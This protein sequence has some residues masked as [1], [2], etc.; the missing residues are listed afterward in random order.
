[1]GYESEIVVQEND[2]HTH[3]VFED[4]KL[5]YLN[6]DEYESEDEEFMQLYEELWEETPVIEYDWYQEN[7]E[8]PSLLP[9]RSTR[10][11]NKP[12]IWYPEY[13]SRT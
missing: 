13:Y 6:E 1:M 12:W 7:L 10:Y 8:H 4:Y 11:R 9:V 3:I 2:P 5:L